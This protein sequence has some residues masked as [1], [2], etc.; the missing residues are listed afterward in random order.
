MSEFGFGEELA[1]A[2]RR[3][4][5]SV[6]QVSDA[7][8]IRPD[9]IRAIEMEDFG[10]M[11]A[12]GF[13]RNQ[14]SAYARFLGLDSTE[15]TQSFL[16]AYND[17]ERN[18]VSSY[19][20]VTDYQQPADRAYATARRAR[21]SMEE[22]NSRNHPGS[23]H[24]RQHSRQSGFRSDERRRDQRQR[25][26]GSEGSGRGNQNRDRRPQRSNRDVGRPKKSVQT[27]G[28]KD[29]RGG[30]NIGSKGFNPGRKNNKYLRRRIIAIIILII[31]IA[32]IAFGVSRCSS[33]D[34]NPNLSSD[35]NVEVTGGSTTGSTSAPDVSADAVT[36]TPSVKTASATSFTLVVSVADGHQSWV[37]V[38]VDGTTSTAEEVTGPQ[39]LT[40]TVT[41]TASIQIGN[42]DYVTVTVNGNDQE[43]TTSDSGLGEVTLTLQD[44]QVTAS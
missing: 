22:E 23:N 6:Q 15:L 12:K 9:I 33:S 38:D 2:R 1:N 36:A 29:R 25:P 44:G 8:R 17:F 11:P 42:P 31:I 43:L 14:I 7:L 16:S 5:Y 32:A 37:E 39:D 26:G 19:G 28:S 4:G 3:S 41:D 35:S 13:A 18:A 27:R 30:R 20:Y 21:Q 10:K 24:Q 34:S 40:Y